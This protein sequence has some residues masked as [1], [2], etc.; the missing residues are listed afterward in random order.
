MK[1]IKKIF[2]I[3]LIAA[4]M[5][6]ISACPGEEPEEVLPPIEHT[7]TFDADGGIFPN[8]QGAVNV[9]VVDGETIGSKKPSDPSYSPDKFVPA[10]KMLYE[11]GATYTFGGWLNGSTAIANDFYDEPIYG[12]ITLK[13]KW[14]APTGIDYSASGA[15]GDS[16]LVKALAYIK[17]HPGTSSTSVKN[18]IL[19]LSDPVA[20]TPQ[21]F[22]ESFT[23]LTIIGLGTGV[24]ITYASGQTG[25][26]LT[27]GKKDKTVS[28]AETVFLTLGKGITLKGKA[29]NNAPV[30]RVQNGATVTMLDGSKVTGNESTITYTGNNTNGL[31]D[32]YGNG[33]AVHVGGATDTTVGTND[34]IGAY[35][36]MK[37]GEISGNENKTPNASNLY[38]GGLYGSDDS[39]ITLEGG[40]ITGNVSTGIPQNSYLTYSVVIILRGGI[41]ISDITLVCDA[42]GSKMG[43]IVLDKFTGETTINLRAPESTVELVKNKWENQQIL[44]IYTGINPNNGKVQVDK[45]TAGDFDKTKFKLGKF[46]T[47]NLATDANITATH[48][49]SDTGTLV[50]N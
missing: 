41:E 45:P 37:G 26:L 18:Y 29:G 1:E 49:L 8:G 36:I 11:K 25:V 28:N 20:C 4:I 5:L 14:T 44:Y 13:A 12:D 40:K 7:V 15:A 30:L 24:E 27:V 17:A 39:I 33:A 34:M 23:D 31:A 6:V 9:T 43:N 50:P 2:G 35:F 16:D 19:A 47:D 42:G 10:A 38:V 46:L 3:V 21:V 22:E 32:Y 48:K